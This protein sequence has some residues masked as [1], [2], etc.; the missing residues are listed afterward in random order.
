MS[1]LSDP[2]NQ[3]IALRPGAGGAAVPPPARRSPGGGG[4]MTAAVAV[5]VVAFAA[6]LILGVGWIGLMGYRLS[7]PKD[8]PSPGGSM[9]MGMPPPGG[10]SG[11]GGPGGPRGPSAKG[12]LAS[13][14]AKLDVLTDKPL[15]VQLSA[16]QRK[17]IREQLNGLADAKELSDDAAK[18]KLEAILDVLNKDQK[19][20]LESAGYRLPGGGG[21]GGPPGG[22]GQQPPPNPFTTETNA[23]HL[24]SLSERLEKSGS[25]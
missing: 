16:D 8:A 25:E 22:M 14:V 13:L 18:P 2:K 12:Q 3:D 5:A 20:A 23:G 11:P 17:Q 24:K 10:S 15:S 6:G 7:P 21:P 9:P 1:P 4:Q 19:A